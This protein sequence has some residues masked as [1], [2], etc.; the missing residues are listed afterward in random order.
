AEPDPIPA[1]VREDLEARADALDAVNAQ[2]LLELSLY[3]ANMLLRDADQMSMAHALELREP[4]LD[5]VL[6]EQVAAL[7]GPLK[8]AGARRGT[9]KALFVDALL[10]GLPGPVLRRRKMG[11]VFPW[12]SWLRHELRD[13][14]DALLGDAAALEAVRLSP[15]G[16]RRLWHDFLARRPGLRYTDVLGLAHPLHWAGRNRFGAAAPCL[17]G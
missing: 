3:L 4:L 17:A 8:L 7:P 13:R 16:V 5:H 15:A 9:A 12:E 14:V 10:E 1:V 11:F 6:V 2:S